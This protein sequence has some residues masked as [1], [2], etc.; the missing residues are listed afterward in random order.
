MRIE[1]GDE[2]CHRPT[3][4]MVLETFSMAWEGP[5]PQNLA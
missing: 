1:E 4:I 5:G 2:G 3:F